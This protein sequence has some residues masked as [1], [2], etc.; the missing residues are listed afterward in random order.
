MGMMGDG[1]DRLAEYKGKNVINGIVRREQNSS[2][3]C[4]ARRNKSS[5]MD[6]DITRI[7]LKVEMP[8]K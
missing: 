3:V 2:N 8:K 6:K 5:E 4:V 7:V 1:L